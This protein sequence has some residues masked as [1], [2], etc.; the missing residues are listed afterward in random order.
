MRLFAIAVT[1]TSLLPVGAVLAQDG[2]RRAGEPPS[3][4]ESLRRARLAKA[5]DLEQP[6]YGFLEGLLYRGEQNLIPQ[7]IAAGYAGFSLASGGM[8]TGNGA[9]LGIGFREPGIGIAYPRHD[10]PNRVEIDALATYSTRRYRQVQGR[11]AWNEIGG[12]PLG[13]SVSAQAYRWP[14]RRFLGRGAHVSDA[15][16]SEYSEDGTEAGADLWVRVGARS[17][18][19][20]GLYALDPDTGPGADEEQPATQELFGPDQAPGL[21]RDARFR[22]V[23]VFAEIDRRDSISYPRA[24]GWYSLRL[25]DYRD[26][27]SGALSFRRYEVDLQQY[28]PFQSRR[29]VFALR[30]LTVISEPRKGADVPVYLWPTLGSSRR[31]RG[32]ESARLQDRNLLLLTA[33]YRWQVWWPLDAALFVDLGN[34]TEHPGDLTGD[35]RAAYGFGLRLHS[36][37]AMIARLDL[38][39]RDDGGLRTH[40]SFTYPFA[41][42]GLE[43]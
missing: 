29:K 9:D 25:S 17:R 4:A 11:V 10:T 43:R 23:D 37:A 28:L 32:F 3:R 20:V 38:A 42:G 7:K 41:P 1:L 27:A 14:R 5:E 40:L 24:G 18:A 36:F 34:V 22:R 21:D 39:V 6:R 12:T 15:D 26:T 13:V 8:P 19:G 16:A 30:A 35:M 31:M 2:E 33:E